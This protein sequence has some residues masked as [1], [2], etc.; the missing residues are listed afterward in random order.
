MRRHFLTLF[1]GTTLSALLLGATVALS[2]AE[3]APPH[4]TASTPAPAKATAA[5]RNAKMQQ[6]VERLVE[7][8]DRYGGTVGVHVMDIATGEQL[9]T[10]AASKPFN[11][12]SNMKVLTAAAALWKL[13]PNHKYRTALYG[14]RSGS[15]VGNLVLRSYG[16][17]S[18]E[19]KDLWEL[20][21][22]L[23]RWGIQRVKGDILVDQSYFDDRYVPPGFEQ[24]PHEWAYF[25]APVSAVA[26]DANT[27][28]MHVAPTRSGERALVTFAPAGFVDLRGRVRTG[29]AG[30]A[31]NVTLRLEASGQ[32]LN[33]R[34]GGA[35]PEDSSRLRV[36]KRVADPTLFA[37]YALRAILT[38]QGIEVTG[39]VKAGGSKA[40]HR[41]TLHNSAPLAK[42]LYRLGKDSDNF[43]A[44]MIF[45]SLN[46]GKERQ[47][48]SSESGAE[49]VRTYLKAINA[50]TKGVDIRNGSG[51]FD[52][53]R[54]T[55]RLL[56]TVLSAAYKDES[57][58]PEFVSHLAV[59][60]QDGTLQRRFRDKRSR[61]RVRAKTG[62]LAAVAAL[63]GYVMRSGS[64]APRPQ[65][66]RVCDAGTQM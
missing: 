18:L 40:R 51:L 53:N 60:G 11:P 21:G 42:L 27:L 22:G 61:G 39:K 26:L 4:S 49:V 2:Q 23:N 1:T 24:Q 25:R 33:A 34:V 29:S 15:S 12:A 28:T 52:T 37:G 8:I 31:Q 19:T 45:K 13:G 38:R 7:T 65:Q 59:G 30:S 14:R 17:P 54:L 56:T 6:A 16:D 55:P 10:H 50:E 44:E 47:G 66:R 41:L 48:L 63:S 62:T 3:P 58:R 64:D 46:G 5:A 36:T 57:M 32:R 20:S 43:Y 9:A 35:I